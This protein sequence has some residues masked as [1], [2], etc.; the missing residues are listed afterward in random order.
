[1]NLSLNNLLF[2]AFISLIGLA[3]LGY[4]RKAGRIPHMAVGLIL[5]VYPYFF[6]SL[7]VEILIGVFLLAA[8]T[9]VNRL[10]F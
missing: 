3:L 4:G 2:G 10:G 6:G 9:L 5:L 7:V 8:L 1:M